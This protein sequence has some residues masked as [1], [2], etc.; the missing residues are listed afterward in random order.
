MLSTSIEQS[1]LNFGLNLLKNL[2]TITLPLRLFALFYGILFL[3]RAL[4]DYYPSVP[5]LNN[6]TRLENTF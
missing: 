3:F 1:L 6:P 4:G 2:L 5:N